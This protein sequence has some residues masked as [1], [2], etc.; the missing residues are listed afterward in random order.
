MSSNE[1]NEWGAPPALPPRRQ[2]A[3]AAPPSEVGPTGPT[4][5]LPEPPR[6]SPPGAR[7]APARRRRR[8][9]PWVLVAMVAV[10]LGIGACTAVA[11]TLASAPVGAANDFVAL[12][13]DGEFEAAYESLCPTARAEIDFEQFQSDMARA[14]EISDYT[15]SSVS[16][17]TGRPTLVSGTIELSGSPRNVGFRMVDIDGTWRV[18]A[19]DRLN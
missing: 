9:W 11:V 14:T 13:D 2:P 18:C 3:S 4:P 10:F 1:P 8:I 5:P 6:P 12:L 16:A 17:G 19:Y 15:L 7:P